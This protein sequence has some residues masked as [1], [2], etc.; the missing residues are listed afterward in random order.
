MA[1]R[2]L[3]VIDSFS[4]GVRTVDADDEGFF[5]GDSQWSG[6]TSWVGSGWVGYGWPDPT[7]E[8]L[9]TPDPVGPDPTRSVRFQ[10]FPGPIRGSSHDRA[11]TREE[12]CFF[13]LPLRAVGF[14]TISSASIFFREM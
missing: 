3:E 1:E 2:L 12:L 8:T 10:K 7:C 9:K 13:P 11:M 6:Q 5:F 4:R 14:L